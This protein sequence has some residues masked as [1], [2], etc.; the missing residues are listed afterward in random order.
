MQKKKMPK[1]KLSFGCYGIYVA[2]ALL[3]VMAG[4]MMTPILKGNEEAVQMQMMKTVSAATTTDVS[5]VIPHLESYEELY[6]MLQ[7]YENSQLEAAVYADTEYGTVM[8]SETADVL[9]ADTGAES[10]RSSTNTQEISVDEADIVKTDG[11]YIYALDKNGVIRIVDAKELEVVSEIS[12]DN[13][14]SAVLEMYVDGDLLQVVKQEEQYMTYEEELEL[15][16]TGSTESMQS[17]NNTFTTRSYYS[18]PVPLTIVEIYDISD[19]AQ[20]QKSESYTQDGSYLSS[21]KNGDVLYLFTSYCPQVGPDADAKE[22]YVPKAGEEYLSYEAIYLPPQIREDSTTYRGGEYLVASAI[23]NETP[24]KAKDCLAVVSGADTFYV[25]ENNIYAATPVWEDNGS[26]TDLIRFGYQDGVFTPGSSGSIPGELNNNFSM[27]EE[28]GYLRIVTTV[29]N[30]IEETDGMVTSIAFTKNNGLY[31]L[32]QNLRIQGKIEGL[33]EGE[34]IKSARF[35]GDTGYF[36]TYRNIDPLFSVDLSDPQSPQLLGELKI[37]GFSEYLHFYGENRL[38]G[39]GWETNPETGA[40]EELKCTMFDISNPREVQVISQLLIKDAVV[41][42]AL[43][44]Y[45]AILVNADKNIFGFA[46][47]VNHGQSYLEYNMEENFYYGV[48]SDTEKGILPLNYFR[49][50]DGEIYE[51]GM[52]YED[53]QSLRG[54]YVGDM[55]YLVSNKGIEAYDMAKEFAFEAAVIW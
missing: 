30:T 26:R 42:D 9:G 55:F 31:I 3:F 45:K 28:D 40:R 49:L 25:S 5:T 50:L 15:P 19:R 32:N 1:K 46:Y 51:E 8:E 54:I 16:N 33:A 47:A 4:A 12:L 52:D 43:T 34:D 24:D 53:Y 2:A 20:P 22:Y 44:N 18:V 11:T 38:L 14:S 6:A 29:E 36:V 39:I 10:D 37:T 17:A 48:F 21:R 23:V 7:A 41:C 35:F 13:S 27:D